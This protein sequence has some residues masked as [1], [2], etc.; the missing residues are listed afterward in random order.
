[1]QCHKWPQCHLVCIMNVKTAEVLARTIEIP[2][3]MVYTYCN[4]HFNKA[5]YL[6]TK[7]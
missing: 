4:I 7:R 2:Q 5:M 1:M 3:D 6:S